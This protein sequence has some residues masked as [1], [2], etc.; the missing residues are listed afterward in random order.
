VDTRKYAYAGLFDYGNEAIG[1][2]HNFTMTAN[3]LEWKSPKAP[4]VYFS[5]STDDFFAP[6][7][8]G[9]TPL[10]GNTRFIGVQ[11]G[12][13]FLPPGA[14]DSYT[15]AIGMADRDPKTGLPAKPETHL[16]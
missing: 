1:E 4:M 8:S 5:N 9:N 2:G 3:F 7:A 10:S 6:V 16:N 15:L 13:S 12:P 14:S 11:W